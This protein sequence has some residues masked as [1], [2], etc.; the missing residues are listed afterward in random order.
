MEMTPVDFVAG[1]ICGIADELDTVGGVFH[2]ANRDP[3]LASE[4]F[5]WLE[6]MGY[7]IEGLPYPEWLEA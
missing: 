7:E 2:L 1:A 5:A 4:V 3:P 6:D